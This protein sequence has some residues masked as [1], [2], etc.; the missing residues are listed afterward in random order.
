MNKT[1]IVVLAIFMAASP[2]VTKAGEIIQITEATR[3]LVPNGKSHDAIDGDWIMKNDKVVAVIGNAIIG[4][5]A[6]MRAQSVQG[7]VIDFTSLADNNDYL[8]AY[9]PHGSPAPDSRSNPVMFADKIVVVKEKGNE[10][11]LQSIRYATKAYPYQSVT[12]YVL[13]DGEDFLRVHTTLSN[14]GNKKVLV[15]VEDV[16][17]LDQD[18]T[19]ASAIG[20]H[21]LAFMYNKWYDAAY[22]LYH[23]AGVYVPGA[24]KT[25][26]D[27]GVGLPVLTYRRNGAVD[28]SKTV[29]LNPKQNIR[30]TRYLVYG[31]DVA[32]IQKSISMLENKRET[33]TGTIIN[34]QDSNKKPVEKVFLEILNDQKEL[35]S[36]GIT[37]RQGNIEV[38]L[39]PGSYK[40]NATKIGHDTI[41][42]DLV[43]VNKPGRLQ[44]TLQP[45]TSILFEVKESVSGRQIPYRIEFKGIGETRDPYLGTSKR[46]QGTN[47]FYYALNKGETRVPVSPGR[48]L[49]AISRGPE[50]KTE[51][52]EVNIQRGESGLVKAD[53]QRLYSSPQWVIADFHNHTTRSGDN[54][55]D[56]KDRVIN[57]SAAGIE[58]APAT[59]HNRISSFTNEIKMLGIEAYIS[60]AAGIELTGPPG[61]SPNHENA[62]PL[63][64][65]E[66]EQGGG[67]PGIDPD[68]YV[69]LERLYNYD[70]EKFKFIQHNHPFIP[71]LYYD[72]N[73]DGIPDSGYGTRK[74]TQA[75]EIQDLMYEILS[76]TN[77]RATT[78]EKN[79][80]AFQWLQMLNQGDK[81]F[82]TATSDCHM[83]GP[84][85]GER[86][87]YVHATQDAPDRI[88]ATE[89]ARSAKRGH[90]IMTNGPFLKV[91]VNGYL[92]GEELKS[93]GNL[94]MNIEVYTN[95]EV[96]IDRIQVLINGRQDKN[97]NFTRKSHP[98][99]F[100][101]F[102]LQFKHTFPLMLEKDANVIVVA[103]GSRSPA[104]HKLNNPSKEKPPVAI[105]NPFFV[106]VDWNGFVPNKDTLGEPLPVVHP[107][108]PKAEN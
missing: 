43:V 3:H 82:G 84:A 88:D 33:A 55:S 29:I 95:N 71:Q 91:D 57:F 44:L 53:L 65:R 92:P 15:P 103:T 47:N 60:S 36:F 54:D 2:F 41:S 61:K 22:G 78:K 31:K 89:I 100:S 23:P 26:H 104:Q 8:V 11:I 72:K 37:D 67:A 83:V 27:P 108:P 25:G 105:S 20:R 10:I 96:E 6:N 68:P 98:S 7:A 18:I 40:L 49:V 35:I 50:Y 5:E 38:P 14:P 59:E 58:F 4:R 62:F 51:Y 79:N 13:K 24:P 52:R 1:K 90:M 77:E 56:T 99:L 80:R 45:L 17:R 34:I 101:A 85:S 63:H 28:T 76:S 32:T 64:I 74:F 102:P 12:E 30:L 46:A 81:I 48:Y 73:S 75:I 94:S 93:N 66:G 87:V 42:S 9:Y 69:Q 19:E 70:G 39:E 97:L 21:R 106:D 107:A 86:F 16:I